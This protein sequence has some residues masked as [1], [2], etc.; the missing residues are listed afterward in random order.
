MTVT[1]YGYKYYFRPCDT[2]GLTQEELQ[3]LA[4]DTGTMRY[5]P[6][7][8]WLLI[9]HVGYGWEVRDWEEEL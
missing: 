6:N 4:D 3:K 9:P 2:K 1:Y 5:E 7:R 8:A